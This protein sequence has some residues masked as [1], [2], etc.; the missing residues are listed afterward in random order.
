MEKGKQLVTGL[1]V[2]MTAYAA[3]MTLRANRLQTRLAELEASHHQLQQK[4]RLLKQS[5]IQLASGSHTSDQTVRE[6]LSVLEKEEGSDLIASP[7]SPTTR[8][9]MIPRIQSK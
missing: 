1:V 3:Y 9:N 8:V 2:V 6:L 4:H 7:E 5:Y